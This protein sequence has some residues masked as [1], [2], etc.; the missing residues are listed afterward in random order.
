MRAVITGVTGLLGKHLVTRCPPATE[1]HGLSRG[2]WPAEL[3]SLCTMHE[4]DLLAHEATFDLLELLAP[5]VV[6][7]AAAEGRVDM[8][9]G[10]ISEHEALNVEM[11]RKL[12][13]FCTR[14]NIRFVFISSN[15]VFGGSKVRYSD[16]SEFDP[17]N[18]YGV[19]KGKAEAAVLQA[20]PSA[21]ILRPILMYGWPFSSGRQNPA[22]QWVKSLR[23]GVPVSVV[24]DVWTQPL[25]AWD[26]ADAV[27]SGAASHLNGGVNVS[28]GESSS[29]Y[30]F[31]LKTAAVF[32]LDTSL[33]LAISSADLPQLAPRPINTEFDLIRLRNDLHVNPNSLQEGLE[34]LRASEPSIRSGNK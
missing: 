15:A 32:D 26:C 25:A 4:V 23:E 18:D 13:E 33:V 7:H 20:N 21:L 9:Q 22:V 8:V 31:A 24:D 29:L 28:G 10:K 1:I 30:E 34:F 12:A 16:D 17:V 19:L 3:E 6:I 14:R 11:G 5:D 2:N 27:W